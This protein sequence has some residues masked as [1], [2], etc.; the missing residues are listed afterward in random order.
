MEEQRDARAR[1]R[2]AAS[3][4]D[5]AARARCA[6]SPARAGFADR[7]HRLRDAR[8]GDRR[9]ARSTREDG[10]VLAKLVES[11]FY[12]TGGGQVADARRRSSA[13]TATARA[14]VEDVVPARR[15]PGARARARGRASCKPA[16]AW[17]RASTAR[18]RHATECN[19]T[20]THL[21]HAALRERL[22]THV[23]Q[24]GSYVGPDKLRFD[25]T[26]GAPLTRRGACATSRT[27][28]TSGS[29]RTSRCARS[30]R[31]STRRERSAR[32][33]CSARSTATSCGW[34]RSAT[35]SFSRELCG[36]THVRSTAEIGVF[37]ITAETSSAA[38]V[39]RIEAV[40]GPGGGRAAARARPR[41]CATSATRLRTAPEQVAEAVA[42][43][44][45][46]RKRSRRLR[47]G[48]RGGRRGRRRRARRPR[49]SRS[50]ASHGAR[51]DRATSPDP[52]ALPD[53]AD[54]LKGK[55]GD[56]A[57]VLG[58]AADGRVAARR[59]RRPGARRARREGRRRRQG[60][61]RRSS[62]AAAAA[63]TRWRRPAAA[64]R[65][66]AARRSPPPARR[67]SARSRADAR[68]RAR[69]RQRPLRRARSATRPARSPRRS[70][71][72]ERPG[73]AA[74][75]CARLATLVARARGRARRRR[76]AAV[77]VAA[78]TPRRR[79]RRARSPSAWRACSATTFPSSS[80]TS[81]SRPA[82]PSRPAGARERGLAR[83][84]AS[85][86]RTGWLDTGLR[87]GAWPLTPEEREAAPPGARA[88]ARR[89]RGPAIRPRR[90]AAAPP[91]DG[92]SIRRSIRTPESTHLAD[93]AAR[94][95]SATRRREWTGER[96]P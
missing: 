84:R 64:T 46:E 5:D 78:A 25:F 38:N 21:L 71:A 72:V 70:S 91:E 55:L 14:R 94:R 35:A 16:S 80:T 96:A 54:R 1:E 47:E 81:A 60:R 3:G 85:C 18:A 48:R 77:A 92:Q 86:S 52:K 23:R 24:A 93:P 53:L 27:A 89:A 90:S 36:G 68:A 12:A 9:S 29:S 95:S 19:H 11:P 40:T 31:R 10:R 63:A 56:A 66:A 61:G 34:S 37:K 15:R 28:S 41:C 4:G 33:R 17:S 75:A 57:I 43:A 83:R 74:R 69:L 6:R 26:H 65:Q 59:D 32:W 13:R 45:R 87:H 44:A 20:A 82:S 2:A 30:R 73:H 49:R 58:A 67:S 39:R 42:R 8:A 50:T 79:A 7:V 22:G 76:A 88:Q 62:A 51:R